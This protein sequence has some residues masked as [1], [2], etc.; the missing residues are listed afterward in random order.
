MKVFLSWS[1]PRSQKVAA[2]LNAWI[3]C[4]IQSVETWFS[5]Q[6]IEDGELWFNSIQ[7]Q[8][9]EIINGIICLTRENKD[10]P[11]ILFE[12][13]GLA[14]GLEKNRV[15]VLMIDLTGDEIILSPLSA[16]N[17]TKPTED[18]IRKLMHVIN[19]RTLK[20]VNP[21][22]LDQVFDKFWPDFEEK[23]KKILEDTEAESSS[24][25]TKLS[26]N[27]DSESNQSVALLREAI[28]GIRN[29][30]KAVNKFQSK[31]ATTNEEVLTAINRKMHTGKDVSQAITEISLF[32]YYDLVV[33]NKENLSEKGL[34]LF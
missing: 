7:S 26:E 18:G 32:D 20:P 31:S 28:K 30:E 16:F 2:L 14:R 33:K 23:F 29:L 6:N 15:Y 9:S 25:I 34:G 17:H 21:V 27:N 12:A 10:Q 13:G 1:K 19:G 4:V 3:P 11:W 8:V 22:V 24:T 5:P